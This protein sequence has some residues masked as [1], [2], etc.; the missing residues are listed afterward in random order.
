MANR[1]SAYLEFDIE[2]DRQ[3]VDAMLTHLDSAL[4]PVGLSLFL[5][6]MVSPWLR[7]R[8]QDRFD[9]EGDDASGTWA[10]LKESTIEFREHG[11]FGEGPIN[12]RTGELEAY[13]TGGNGRVI[14]TPLG[15]SLAYPG[16]DTV[17]S[18]LVTKVKTAQQGRSFPRTV[19]RP[20]LAVNESDLAYV[21]TQLAFFVQSY[22]GQGSIN[23]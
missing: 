21:V 3:G 2:G 18:H 15:A 1:T 10:P 12:R 17:S 9:S 13:I 23:P 5:Y 22:R 14:A 4:S 19:A 11:G 8:A 16:T 20:V 6:G 7:E